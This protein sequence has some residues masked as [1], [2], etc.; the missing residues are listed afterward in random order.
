MLRN[1]GTGRKSICRVMVDYGKWHMYGMLFHEKKSA[2]FKTGISSSIAL[3]CSVRLW[4][5]LRIL[6][7]TG[8]NERNVFSYK[9]EKVK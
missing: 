8:R 5:R 6:R 4:N 2:L 3:K 7:R 1:S 9:E